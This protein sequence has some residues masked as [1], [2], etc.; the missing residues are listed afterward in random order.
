MK[1]KFHT[2][3][4]VMSILTA[5][6]PL[7][8]SVKAASEQNQQSIR[9]CFVNL[10][11]A[12]NV[13]SAL[14]EGTSINI[15][16][17][18]DPGHLVEGQIN[19]YGTNSISI[20]QSSITPA[21]TDLTG[22]GSLDSYCIKNEFTNDVN[23]EYTYTQAVI[24]SSFD[25]LPIRYNDEISINY[26]HPDIAFPYSGE[27]FDN[28]A[29]NEASRNTNAD[30]HITMSS[31]RADRTLVIVSQLDQN[32]PTY[33][34]NFG[35]AI[36]GAN[37]YTLSTVPN[38]LQP[39]STMK[40]RLAVQNMGTLK[41]LSSLDG[42]AINPVNISYHWK[43]LDD[44]SLSIYNGNRAPLNHD[45]EYTFND[46]NIDLTVNAPNAPGSHQ[47]ILDLVHEGVTWFSAKGANTKTFNIQVGSAQ[48]AAPVIQP[49][50][51]NPQ[52]VTTIRSLS[53]QALTATLSSS[54]TYTVE[55]YSGNPNW[56]CGGY[57]CLVGIAEEFYQ[58][59]A[60]GIPNSYTGTDI[61]ILK[62]QCWWPIYQANLGYWQ[63]Y[64]PPVYAGTP[65]NYIQVG[66]VLTIPANGGVV[67]PPPPPVLSP[68]VNIN[69]NSG[70][71]L[72]DPF[73]GLLG[74]WTGWPQ[75]TFDR[76]IAW[77]GSYKDDNIKW[78]ETTRPSAPQLTSI[79]TSND[80]NSATIYGV[81]IPKNFPMNIR[82]W[83]E[84]RNCWACGS[85]WEFAYQQGTA[86]NVKVVFFKN[87][88][89]YLG[90]VWN[91]NP[92]GR[93]S[94]NLP[95][96]AINPG[97]NIFAE[98]QIEADYTFNGLHWWSN[99]T[100]SR[101][102]NLRDPKYTGYPYF[103][104]GGSGS[105]RVPEFYA[106]LRSNEE[107]SIDS[108]A[109]AIGATGASSI[110]NI[111]GYPAKTYSN[112][113]NGPGAIIYVNNRAIYTYGGTWDTFN[114]YG[115]KCT[116]FS[117]PTDD[118]H[119]ASPGVFN[120]P[121]AYQDFQKGR[122]YW[123]WKYLGKFTYG[124]IS[125]KY[126]YLGGTNS[127]YGWPTSETFV[128]NS[129][130]CQNFEAGRICTDNYQTDPGVTYVDFTGVG[131]EQVLLEPS[132]ND[133]I[134]T[135]LNA[136][137]D[138]YRAFMYTTNPLDQLGK[139][140][141][142]MVHYIYGAGKGFLE[143]LDGAIHLVEGILVQGTLPSIVDGINKLFTDKQLLGYIVQ[144]QLDSFT[145]L[146][147]LQKVEALGNLTQNI[148]LVAAA[149]YGIVKG[150]VNLFTSGYT[151]LKE[152]I[153]A[154]T[155]AEEATQ[156]VYGGV[157][158]IIN[159]GKNGLVKIDDIIT[160]IKGMSWEDAKSFVL[161]LTISSKEKAYA[162]IT[163][164]NGNPAKTIFYSLRDKDIFWLEEGTLSGKPSGLV[165]IVESHW[166]D[167]VRKFGI[168]TRDEL[169]ELVKTTVSKGTMSSNEPSGTT[170]TYIDD[171]GR[172][173]VVNT[174]NN[175]YIVGANPI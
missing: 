158:A 132:I 47:L 6:M 165:H 35:D 131:N 139:Q 5:I 104:S 162:L 31:S 127:H 34:V 105:I 145:N 41:W 65:W 116:R 95:K 38:T 57:D 167:F 80:G 21:N 157:E 64:I 69:T 108:R 91:D 103:A 140:A 46:S 54:T 62:T 22:S 168:T 100:E 24:N 52:P 101:N 84:F 135:A 99:T 151:F 8:G 32:L 155:F 67:N 150:A 141:E 59:S 19:S 175:G 77:D 73:A 129:Y 96:G 173:M 43:N 13:I 171:L 156:F 12:G 133:S 137:I 2:I 89:Q 72:A 30:G 79:I 20:S 147:F 88:W 58:C 163:S 92:S 110:T 153:I 166:D 85:G 97:D 102:F 68:V 111:C 93:F 112:V 146:P 115:D 90:E 109:I 142:I 81:G 160:A 107:K 144:G 122:I 114:Y 118:P 149:G 49:V 28:I 87:N 16:L 15:N 66:W 4:L 174:G 9:I 50:T 36:A 51:S 70:A 134:S 159:V 86:Q 75:V 169:L 3:A 48:Q 124:E 17:Y 76:W 82:V 83:N 148:V 94:I 1:V 78:S 136:F 55:P 117:V 37:E 172:G 11:N 170:F 164:A 152:S 128:I 123:S 71:T 143:S 138:E 98:V 53:P 126:E 42:T 18:T 14:P 113:I 106:D 63:G 154:G 61:N 130:V 74:T 44:D 125:N 33:D 119:T 56:H 10:N 26:V 27:W 39:G 60:N 121:G 7:T 45:I 161:D 29:G 23:H 25:W 120:T 40:L